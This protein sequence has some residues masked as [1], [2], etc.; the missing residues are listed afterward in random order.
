MLK[1]AAATGITGVIGMAA[2]SGTVTATHCHE[3]EDYQEQGSDDGTTRCDTCYDNDLL[4]SSA[5]EI[6]HVDTDN[7]N[8][9]ASHQF[10]FSTTSICEL[11]NKDEKADNITG[12]SW[13]VDTSR[14]EFGVDF[15]ERLTGAMP[16]EDD[17][18][19]DDNWYELAKIAAGTAAKPVD[20]AFD[21]IEAA[22]AIK[23]L[24][25]PQ[26]DS[27]YVYRGEYDRK[28]NWDLIPYQS[29]VQ[30]YFEVDVPEGHDG[31]WVRLESTTEAQGD[32]GCCPDVSVT[33]GQWIWMDYDTVS[34]NGS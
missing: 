15:C 12:H 9:Y 24:I 27:D 16:S 3:E 25:D 33:D 21:S 28:D 18:D 34:I 31:A 23:N 6:G 4:L 2:S 7:D 26:E 13:K 5:T 30:G 17:G 10:H 20:V 32:G 1:Q 19:V 22:K 14:G 11:D 8:G 29:K